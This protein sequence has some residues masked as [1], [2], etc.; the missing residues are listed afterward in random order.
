MAPDPSS[1]GSIQRWML[2]ALLTPG[3]GDVA[4]A[5]AML[6]P[7]A[8]LPPEACLAIYQR[9]YI[10][11]LRKC[12]EEQFPAS[13]HALGA[14]LFCDFADS[15]LR[16]CPSDSYTLYEL[17]RRF[18]EW[19]KNNRPDRDE[20]PEQ[21]EGWIDFL[22]DLANYERQLFCLFDAPGH[23]GKG[24]PDLATD[25]GALTLQ[26]CLRL[27]QHRY[28]V[29]WYYHEACAGRRPDVPAA[30]ISHAV[31]LRRDY[32]THTYPVTP[33]HFDFLQRV[34]TEGNVAGAL[35]ALAR[36]TRLSLAEVQRS[37]REEVRSAWIE[38]GFFMVHRGIAW[39]GADNGA[40]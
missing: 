11:R 10:L 31:I 26:P 35:A 13:C 15:Y 27:M 40:L 37:W 1:L 36:Q 24:W 25:D 9:S 34:R 2:E 30:H 39:R 19:L 21:R 18:P 17:G 28:P 38:A 7:G 20:A 22:I 3:E 23:E 12:L 4:A 5:R 6:L 32:L 16:D 29:A 8:R 14:Q 33:F